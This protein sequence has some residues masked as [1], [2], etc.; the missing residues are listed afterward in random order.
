MRDTTCAE[1]E[2]RLAA[3]V[4]GEATGADRALVEEHLAACPPCRHQAAR[5]RAGHQLIRARRSALGQ[6]APEPLRRRCAAAGAAGHPR[7]ALRRWVPVSVAAT[8][9]LAAAGVIF[10]SLNSPAELLATQLA[11]DHVKCFKFPPS[12]AVSDSAA[13]ERRWEQQEGWAITIPRSW[14]EHEVK[15][16]GVRKCLS[17]EGAVAHVMY[18][19]RGQPM[20]LYVMRR[21]D[22]RAGAL[23]VLGHN[24]LIWSGGDRTYVVLG[25]E[26]EPELQQVAAYFRARAW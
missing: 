9:V 3:Y 25:Q 19:C 15:L 14:P 7:P 18:T 8:L 24:A 12:T 26:P 4:D 6:R 20:S 21:A 22:R 11:V 13:L 17:S 23:E 16:I 5:E 10:Y 2:T 1:I